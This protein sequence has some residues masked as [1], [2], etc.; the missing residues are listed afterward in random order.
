M[1]W[2][3]EINQYSDGQNMSFSLIIGSFLFICYKGVLDDNM[4]N[5]VGSSSTIY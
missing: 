1:A 2:S 5:I 4:W 3:F